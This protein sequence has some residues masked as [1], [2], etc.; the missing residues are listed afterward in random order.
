VKQLLS[1][2]LAAGVAAFCVVATA[3]AASPAQ[4]PHT[5]KFS[6]TVNAPWALEEDQED[7]NS[8]ISAAGLCRSAPFDTVNA[9]GPLGTNVDAIV[10]DA[11]NN[12]GFSNLGCTTPQNETTIAVNPTNPS[13]LVAGANDYRVCCDS[14]GLNDATG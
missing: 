7:I 10:G 2:A 5:W 3:G 1:L 8:T 11:V 14:T 13:N 6:P 12:S 9:Y 4:S